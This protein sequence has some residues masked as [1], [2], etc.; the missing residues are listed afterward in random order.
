MYQHADMGF[1]LGKFPYPFPDNSVDEIL[2]SHILEHLPDTVAALDE[3]WRIVKPGGKIV[4]RV[5]SHTHIDSVTNPT[6][7]RFFTSRSIEYFTNKEGV[8]E[9]YGNAR[10]KILKNQL[11]TV[12]KPTDGLF[13]KLHAKLVN[14]LIRLNQNRM[15][16]FIIL[17]GGISEICWELEVIK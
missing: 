11:I 9:H 2:A 13:V 4:I 3:W 7:K 12:V 1:D 15:E 8:W 6:H 10:F 17:F 16:R 5:P 14:S